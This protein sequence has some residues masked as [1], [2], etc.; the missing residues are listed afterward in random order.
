M[1]AWGMG[2]RDLIHFNKALLVKQFWRLWKIMDSLTAR[3]Y[4]TK[5]FQSCSIMEARL[6]LK[7]SF[8]WR[9]IHGAGD[10]V[11]EGLIWRIGDGANVRIW[12]DK[13]VPLLHT[14]KIQSP[15][16]PLA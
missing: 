12:G 2:F 1:G 15:P 7:P 9:S 4:K 3:I 5:Y 10:L 16:S 14:F 11:E 6:G 13:W 8:A